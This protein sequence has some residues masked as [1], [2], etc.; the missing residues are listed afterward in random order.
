[1]SISGLDYTEKMAPKKRLSDT[2]HRGFLS[3]IAEKYSLRR[4]TIFGNSGVN[5]REQVTISKLS[6]NWKASNA[7]SSN[8][9]TVFEPVPSKSEFLFSD[10]SKLSFDHNMELLS[11]NNPSRGTL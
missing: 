4:N 3:N 5:Y 9:T 1:M 2:N 11:K 7:S 8:L 6:H 10:S